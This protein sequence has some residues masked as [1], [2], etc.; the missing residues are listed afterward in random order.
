[1]AFYNCCGSLSLARKAA[2]PNNP[3]EG[4]SVA[5][6]APDFWGLSL[7]SVAT[8]GSL[9]G[10]RLTANRS[11][12]FHQENPFAGK[13]VVSRPGRRSQVVIGK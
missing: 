7:S 13:C 3:T 11:P 8:R 4:P 5:E 1:M 6:V 9:F 10:D 12:Q 2:K